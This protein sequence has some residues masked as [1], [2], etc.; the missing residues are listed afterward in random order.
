VR[1]IAPIEDGGTEVFS[2]TRQKGSPSLQTNFRF[3]RNA[4]SVNGKPA[5][6]VQL[7]RQ[8][9]IRVVRYLRLIIIHPIYHLPHLPSLAVEPFPEVAL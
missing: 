3:A 7:Y 5:A 6:I 2:L 1:G 8:P 9:R 4:G